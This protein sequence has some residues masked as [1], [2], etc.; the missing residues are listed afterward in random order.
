MVD[1]I[2][3]IVKFRVNNAR[4]FI[5]H[6]GWFDCLASC[7]VCLT[8]SHFAAGPHAKQSFWKSYLLELNLSQLMRLMVFQCEYMGCN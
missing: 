8:L 4:S 2:R 5:D 6:L 3:V 7:I 1:S